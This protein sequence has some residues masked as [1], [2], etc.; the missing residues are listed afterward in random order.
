MTRRG[1]A[2]ACGLLVFT[3]SPLLAQSRGARPDPIS[4]TWTGE[5][6][7]T[8]RPTPVPVTFQLKFDGKHV[9]GTFSGL[10]SP[11]DVKNGTFDAKTGALKL[12]LGKTGDRAVLLILEGILA[13]GT[14][15]GRFSGEMSGQF[16]LTKKR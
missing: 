7:M 8:G 12:Q 14:A 5:L 16:K 11:G 15:S 10:P 2:V 13:K 6:A 4:G 1:F 9:S 3:V